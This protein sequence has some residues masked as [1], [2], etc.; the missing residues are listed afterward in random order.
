MDA[1]I[2]TFVNG[3][4]TD[5]QVLAVYNGMNRAQRARYDTLT[6]QG[7]SDFLYAIAE[8]KK[9]PKH[10]LNLVYVVINLLSVIG[11]NV[12][13]YFQRRNGDQVF[14]K[15]WNNYKPEQDV[16]L[17]QLCILFGTQI[18][19][20]L[21]TAITERLFNKFQNMLFIIVLIITGIGLAVAGGLT[22]TLPNTAISFIGV[23]I[24]FAESAMYYFSIYR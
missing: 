9:K 19:I 11:F 23:G 16:I 6:D 1:R 10:Y 20:I 14:I 12:W 21:I 18:V 13:S 22:W 3:V 2:Y 15:C 7:K 4:P 17:Y 24:L 5:P 8:E